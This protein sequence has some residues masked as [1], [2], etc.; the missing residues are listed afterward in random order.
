[1]FLEQLDMRI[2]KKKI[3]L[4]LHLTDIHKLTQNG[5]SGQFSSVAQSCLTF[6]DPWTAARQASLSITS[7][8][9]LL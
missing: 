9:S 2:E 3:K 8:Q 7:Y 6:C 1:M 5:P 4:E